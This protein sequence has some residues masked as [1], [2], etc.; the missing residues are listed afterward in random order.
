M[1]GRK[2]PGNRAAA[3][4]PI[5]AL[6]AIGFVSQIYYTLQS[7]GVEIL[8][9]GIP[10][11]SADRLIEQV[12]HLAG[13]ISTPY[14]VSDTTSSI[15]AKLL[16]GF[17]SGKSLEFPS[18]DLLSNYWVAPASSDR[19]AGLAAIE[20][21]REHSEQMSEEHFDWKDGAGTFHFDQVG[22]PPRVPPDEVTLLA[23]GASQTILNNREASHDPER[24]LISRPWSQW[25]NQ[26]IF[27]ESDRGKTYSSV[28]LRRASIYPVEHDMFFPR[29]LMSAINRYAL[30]EVVNPSDP[31]RV[32]LDI[33]ASFRPDKQIRLPANA[34]V[35]GETREPLR[36]VGRGSARVVSPPVKPQIIRGR[37]Y[38]GLD[39]GEEPIQVP[40]PRTG[41]MRMYG[42]GIHLDRRW[43][44]V[45]GRDISLLSDREYESWTP[46]SKVAE[47]PADL[48]AADLEYSGI[49][50][51]G[52]LG[53]SC[54]VMLTQPDTFAPL[55]IRGSVPLVSDKSFQTEIRV[56]VNGQEVAR[57]QL[58]VGDFELMLPI[59]PK[60][61]KARVG[62]EFS[63]SQRLAGADRRL[64]AARLSFIGFA[65]AEYEDTRSLRPA[66][67]V[68]PKQSLA[69]GDGWYPEET[70]QQQ[71]FRWVNEDAEIFAGPQHPA[72]GLNIDMEPGPGCGGGCTISVLDGK[73][74]K[75]AS[76]QPRGRGKLTIPPQALTNST[77][78][79]TLRLVADGG[80]KKTPSDPRILNFRVFDIGFDRHNTA[81]GADPDDISVSAG[82]SVGAGWY[83]AETYQ[84]ERFRWVNNDA[85]I[86]VDPRP[87]GAGP[88]QLDVAVGPGLGGAPLT[89]RILDEHGTQVQAAQIQSRGIVKLFLP[90]KK[91]RASYRLH[92]EGGGAK[93]PNDP[94]ILNFRVFKIGYQNEFSPAPADI[95][96][97]SS[98]LKLG[99]GWYPFETYKGESFRWVNNDAAFVVTPQKSAVVRLDAELEPGPG[100][101]GAPL[102]LSLINSAGHPV[103]TVEVQKRQNVEFVLPVAPGKSEAFRLH[104]NGGGHS[105]PGD[106]RTLNFRVFRLSIAQP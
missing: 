84:G 79:L 102:Y 72:G 31:V 38:I 45:F 13:V 18:S 95:V 70:A 82:V 36:L 62:L 54:Y 96:Q 80:G 32:L 92:A 1:T 56:T 52:W 55:V 50:E 81:T 87:S 99:S 91:A 21:L 8:Q 63:K 66:D 23:L 69:L 26:L 74:A 100:V 11:G 89:L 9:V 64:L 2:Q 40:T 90:E 33:S 37:A 94:R 101:A 75:V 103:Q 41:L 35:I 67:I 4:V 47:L 14:V 105:I 43:F 76:T 85:I 61:G 34:A 73:G 71:H 39:L 98:V 42:E 60:S 77:G 17:L 19:A 24:D 44:V 7:R 46:P 86:Q 104:V 57:R 6:A 10:N 59:P 3:V 28:D 29:R 30:F 93:I 53:E 22:L 58:N 15:F 106:P 78:I 20:F 51:D 88:L 27:I 68:E 12:K 97:G 48:G 83:P 65:P 16:G 25:K 49:V 5:L